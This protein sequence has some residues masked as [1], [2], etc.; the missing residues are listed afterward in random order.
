MGRLA[1]YLSEWKRKVLDRRHTEDVVTGKKKLTERITKFSVFVAELEVEVVKGSEVV[2][3][4]SV[5]LK[6]AEKRAEDRV[7]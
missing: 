4:L 6:V 7:R 2:A 1:L 3:D 5:Q